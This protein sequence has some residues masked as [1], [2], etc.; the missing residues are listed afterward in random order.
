VSDLHNYVIFSHI[1]RQT[2][3]PWQNDIDLWYPSALSM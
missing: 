1:L 3:N 2:S